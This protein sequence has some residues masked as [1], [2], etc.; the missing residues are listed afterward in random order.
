MQKN[1]IY[2]YEYKSN[3]IKKKVIMRYVFIVTNVIDFPNLK[4][5]VKNKDKKKHNNS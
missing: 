2:K 4:K 3:K 5:N 1:I